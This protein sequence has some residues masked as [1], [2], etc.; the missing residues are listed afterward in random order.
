[1]KSVTRRKGFHEKI[2]EF[3]DLIGT[4][5]WSA[6]T[7]KAIQTFKRMNLTEDRKKRKEETWRFM[8][9][10]NRY[11][12][13]PS[14]KKRKENRGYRQHCKT[15]EKGELQTPQNENCILLSESY[16]SAS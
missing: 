14:E 6:M 2:H 16:T 7:P 8:H 1:M 10:C 5:V 13:S 15:I 3:I 11:R 12:P 9:P 4:K